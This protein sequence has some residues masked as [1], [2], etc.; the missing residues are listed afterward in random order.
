MRTPATV[1][2]S[3]APAV[4]AAPRLQASTFNRRSTR[5]KYSLSPCSGFMPPLY[6]PPNGDF[7][8][9]FPRP[10]EPARRSSRTTRNPQASPHRRRP[11]LSR[12]PPDLYFATAPKS[13]AE[14]RRNPTRAGLHSPPPV[15]DFRSAAARRRNLRAPGGYSAPWSP[16]PA[17]AR[18]FRLDRAPLRPRPARFPT[19]IPGTI[20]LS[21]KSSGYPGVPDNEPSDPQKVRR[22]RAQENRWRY[23]RRSTR[24][25]ARALRPIVFPAAAA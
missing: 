21:A 16:P 22:K 9:A 7:Q 17:T 19:A 14:S 13:P 8:P 12:E 4:S 3:A 5:A 1:N 6:P 25:P 18:A 20:R 10:P 15:R 24:T 11:R 2:P 23:C